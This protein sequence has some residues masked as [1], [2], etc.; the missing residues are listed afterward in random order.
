MILDRFILLAIILFSEGKRIF[1]TKYE[2]NEKNEP[3]KGQRE[4][5]PRWKQ[6]EETLKNEEDVAESG[7]IFI[8]NLSY[9]TTEDEIRSLFEK[10]GN[11]F[12]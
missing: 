8:R 2:G 1:V 7:R 12:S 5:H 3:K 6:Q 4:P 9:T 10:Y 11:F